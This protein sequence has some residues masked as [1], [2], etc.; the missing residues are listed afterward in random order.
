MKKLV[1]IVLLVSLAAAGAA[2]ADLPVQARGSA[3][4]SGGDVAAAKA[5]ALD[6]ALRQAV[7]QAAAT[8]LTPEQR[9]GA[10]ELI[11]KR[12]LRR[13]RAYVLRY[14]VASEGEAGGV[15]S[16]TL[17]TTIADGPLGKDV[18]ALVA[19]APG[20]NVVPEERAGRP[21]L[22][23]L[24]VTRE[25]D[26]TW[27]TFG[28]GSGDGGPA[29]V[30]LGRELEARGFQI[31]PTAG[32]EVPVG[33][34]GE[35]G[36]PLTTAQA[37]AIAR[38]A[39][40]GGAVVAGVLVKDGGRIRGTRRAGAEVAMRLRLDDA[41]AASRVAE[42]EIAAAGHGVDPGAAAADAGRAAALLAGRALGQRLESHWPPAEGPTSVEGILVRLRGVARG[43]DVAI[44]ARALAGGP[45]V[46][47]VVLQRLARHEVTLLVRG[48]AQPR[49]L[50]ALAAGTVVPGSRVTSTRAGDADVE[51]ELSVDPLRP[52][53]PTIEAPP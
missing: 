51:V 30:A 53:E 35:A 52:A 50:A 33:G 48:R 9:Q 25:G 45:G 42:A 31:A 28:R 20:P 32:L 46:R 40:A 14:Q 18:R 29:A 13:A 49:A 44:F 6:D 11:K 23:L 7:D 1:S 15:Y 43:P 2:R 4:I 37:A 47:S 17:D 36:L 8:L 5:R 38:Q 19:P 16:V 24:A 41:V 21:P 39:G 22:A 12:I 3:T 26:Q 34:E 27:A 10:A